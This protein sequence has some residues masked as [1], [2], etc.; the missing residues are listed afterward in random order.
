MSDLFSPVG[1]DFRHVSPNLAKA[2]FAGTAISFLSFTIPATLVAVFVTPWAWIAAGIIT[3]LHLWVAILITRQVKALQYALGETELFVR[4]G[5]MFKD[6]TA[7]PYGRIQ[8]VDVSEG[9]IARYFGMAEIKLHTASAA[10]DAT[11][12]GIPT[13]EAAELRAFLSNRCEAEMVGI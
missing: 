4:K 12:P 9:P 5:I 8:Y 6:M 3:I 13:A 10:T 2:R 7:V 1:I 11:I